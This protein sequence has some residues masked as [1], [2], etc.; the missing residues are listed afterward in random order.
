MFLYINLLITTNHL[1]IGT[2]D[3]FLQFYGKQ[4]IYDSSCYKR[5]FKKVNNRT[6]MKME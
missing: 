5:T 6:C 3:Q 2:L 1:N 4:N